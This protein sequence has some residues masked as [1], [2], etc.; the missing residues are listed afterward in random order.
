MT[1]I[2]V[3]HGWTKNTEKW[4]EF[5]NLLEE[6]NITVEF[7][8]IPGLTGGLR[9]VWGL[10]DY[11]KW[12][13]NIVD[14]NNEKV[15][16]IGHSNG[17]R[18]S[19]A[20]TTLFPQK[21]KKLVLIDSSGIYHNEFVLNIKKM[22]FKFLAK[23]GKRIT[24][25]P[26]MKNLLYKLARESDYKDLDEN[27]KKTF[28]NLTSVDLKPTLSSIKAP[29]L[30]IWGDNDKIEPL[31]YGIQMNELIQNSKLKVI[32]DARHA[33]QYTHPLEVVNLITDFIKS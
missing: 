21:V 4:Q 15:I 23:T 30:I 29:T 3:L 7:P 12:L 11:I 13:K 18:I 14:K 9:E 1:R 31:S 28:I 16:L 10:D 32:K 27:I 2:I 6:K 5:L 20:F 33:P 26:R 17:G 22:V 8:K 25:S 24:S 19:L